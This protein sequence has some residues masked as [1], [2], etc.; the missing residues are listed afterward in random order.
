MNVIEKY[1][2]KENWAKARN[3]IRKELKTDKDNHWLITRLGLTFYEEKEYKRALH[4][5]EKAKKL[6]PNCPLVLWD[7]A[8]TL[9][10]LGKEKEAIKVFQKIINKGIEE[11]AYGECGEGI[12]WAKA[13]YADCFYRLALSYLRIGQKRKAKENFEKHFVNR[14]RGIPSIYKINEVKKKY[15]KLLNAI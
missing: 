15:K 8:G 1:I 2:E 11:I 10:M 14:G 6:A 9:D 7:Y 12:R 13:L 4:Y 3:E 5:S